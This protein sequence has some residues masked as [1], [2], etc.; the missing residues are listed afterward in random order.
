MQNPFLWSLSSHANFIFL[1][2]WYHSFKR[3]LFSIFL[4][5]VK[6]FI[7]FARYCHSFRKFG[8][9]S[10][11]MCCTYIT[12]KAF[13]PEIEEIGFMRRSSKVHS[14]YFHIKTIPSKKRNLFSILLLMEWKKSKKNYVSFFSLKIVHMTVYSSKQMQ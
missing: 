10:V 9:K 4:Y 1:P 8:C 14:K 7:A 2:F 5:K 3:S 12:V 11:A 6:L 13:D